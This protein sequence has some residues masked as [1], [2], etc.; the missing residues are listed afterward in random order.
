MYASF[1][2]GVILATNASLISSMGYAFP[3]TNTVTESSPESES[4]PM[5]SS[6]STTAE[7]KEIYSY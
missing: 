1:S 5:I 7:I 2:C 6:S 4:D 3:S